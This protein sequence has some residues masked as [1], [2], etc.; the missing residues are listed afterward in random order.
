MS[1]SEE[2]VEDMADGVNSRS[3]LVCFIYAL[4]TNLEKHPEDFENRDLR[5]YLGA[6]ARF[7]NDAHGYYHN[8]EL[9]VNADVPSWR[10]FADCLRA[11]RVYD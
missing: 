10:L 7:L 6:L 8:L 11:A 1:E 4:L 5:D 2:H 9:N 3:D